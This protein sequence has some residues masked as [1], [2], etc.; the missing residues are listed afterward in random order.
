M[1][2][3]SLLVLQDIVFQTVFNDRALIL[4]RRA[5]LCFQFKSDNGV[6]FQFWTQFAPRF[7]SSSQTK[8]QK[9]L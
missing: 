7:I 5:P 8:N 3:D 6:T 9:N 4:A 1:R 2:D